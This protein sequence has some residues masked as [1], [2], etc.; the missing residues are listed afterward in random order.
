MHEYT[1]LRMVSAYSKG[2]ELQFEHDRPWHWKDDAACAFQPPSLFELASFD[3]PIAEGI[4]LEVDPSEENP[5]EIDAKKAI[6]DLNAAN[7]ERAIEICNTCP[8]LRQCKEDAEPEDFYW[9][10]RAGL[11]P[12]LYNPTGQGR[13]SLADLESRSCPEGHPM[14]RVSGRW[15]CKACNNAK[16]EAKRREDGV[17]PA[18]RRE[19][20][21]RGKKCGKGLHDEWVMTNQGYHECAPCKDERNRAKRARRKERDTISS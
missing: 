9:T 1:Q 17:Q 3:S 2:S 16:A 18:V 11:M 14:H 20:V 7:F 15:R 12:A 5:R 21:A 19:T 8:V 4:A 6:K 10:V 13:P